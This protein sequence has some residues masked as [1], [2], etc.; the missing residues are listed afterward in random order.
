MFQILLVAV[1]K[2]MG[3]EKLIAV[4]SFLI[5]FKILKPENSTTFLLS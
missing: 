1:N 4:N 5:T 3:V 2:I